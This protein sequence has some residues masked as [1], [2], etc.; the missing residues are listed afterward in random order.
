MYLVTYPGGDVRLAGHIMR[1]I[2]RRR[3]R[4]YYEP[5]VGETGAVLYRVVT[6]GVVDS[7][8]IND[9][10]PV[11]VSLWLCV[12]DDSCRREA[13]EMLQ[14]LELTPQH[15]KTV[16]RWHRYLVTG[17]KAPVKN[18]TITA[19]E[20]FLR[21]YTYGGY[22]REAY[23]P[24]EIYHKP[25]PWVVAERVEQYV[26]AVTRVPIEVRFGD[27][28]NTVSDVQRGDLVYLDPPHHNVHRSLVAEFGRWTLA[29]LRRLVDWIL[30][31]PAT[32]VLKYTYSRDAEAVICSAMRCTM[33]E[34]Q[35]AIANGSNTSRVRYIFA[36]HMP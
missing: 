15:L 32:V 2:P 13:L 30:S 23:V 14:G 21:A 28:R 19:L 8:V 33:H 7:V 36:V 35:A 16:L 22:V 26:K 1:L 25:T 4:R 24:R 3:Y 18:P 10:N 31:S 17:L 27:W 9:A 5:F 34:T 11:V 6:S 29:D 12:T 20:L